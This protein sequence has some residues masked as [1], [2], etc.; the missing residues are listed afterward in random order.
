MAEGKL[1]KT[2]RLNQLLDFVNRTRLWID[3]V[4]GRRSIDDMIKYIESRRKATKKVKVEV[5]V[6]AS[7]KT[8]KTSKGKSKTKK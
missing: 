5:K 6:K 7:R 3:I 1:P 4:E 2:V 8:K